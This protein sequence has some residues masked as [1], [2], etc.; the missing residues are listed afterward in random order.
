MNGIKKSAKFLSGLDWH[1]ISQLL[2]RMDSETAIMLRREI[3][4]VGNISLAE[5]DQL[6]N[7]F[8]N[9][10]GRKSRQSK[11]KFVTE[12]FEF[13]S[14]VYGVPSN[15]RTASG[16]SNLTASGNTSAHVSA[17]G[18]N[19]IPRFTINQNIQQP[20]RLPEQT[21]RQ[22]DHQTDYQSD[23]Q[24][25]YQTVIPQS[26]SNIQNHNVGKKRLFEFLFNESPVRIAEAVCCE[27]PQTIAV[28]LAGL[29]DGLAGGTLSVFPPVLQKNVGRRLAEIKLSGFDLADNPVV[30]EIES[31]L[32]RR[33][34]KCCGV[35][36]DDLDRLDDVELLDLFRSV[37]M[38]TAMCALVGAKP[39]FI[40]R[41][42]GK[43]T[44]TEE[45]IMRK[46]LKDAGMINENEVENAR[47]ILIE[48]AAEVLTAIS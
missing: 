41:I 42:T 18:G 13:S 15:A 47:T 34:D 43:F 38:R 27:H 28:V 17:T 29:P 7:E 44:P 39:R 1:T 6:A 48:K 14:G 5:S 45:F 36:F 16:L 12:T 30:L 35:S 24:S 4:S 37:D 25:D 31:E 32:K 10:A 3:M 8:L 2:D 26:R 22:S 40:E 23:H 33:F 9:A 19:P 46:L 11:N 21:N 20:A